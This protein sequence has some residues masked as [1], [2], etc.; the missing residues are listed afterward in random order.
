[1]HKPIRFRES[2][3]RFRQDSP[4]TYSARLAQVKLR[5][6]KRKSQLLTEGHQIDYWKSVGYGFFASAIFLV[7]ATIKESSSRP[8]ILNRSSELQKRK[9]DSSEDHNS[10]LRD[11]VSQ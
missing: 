4:S 8:S 3:F 9:K 2:P 6:R 1:L 11:W 10:P 5:Y 7:W